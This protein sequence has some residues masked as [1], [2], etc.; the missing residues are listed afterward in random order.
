M[1][2]EVQITQYYHTFRRLNIARKNSIFISTSTLVRYSPE[3]DH[4]LEART[5]T[6]QVNNTLQVVANN[7]GIIMVLNYETRPFQQQL[8]EQRINED[9]VIRDIPIYPRPSYHQHE[10]ILGKMP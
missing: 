5:W 6:I 3:H 1:K 9:F 4:I 2:A 7:V 8:L 10:R